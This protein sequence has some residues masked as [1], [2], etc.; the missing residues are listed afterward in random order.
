MTWHNIGGN[1]VKRVKFL[2]IFLFL[3]GMFMACSQDE[4]GYISFD[5]F[6]VFSHRGVASA[7]DHSFEGYDLAIYQG[8]SFIEIDLRMSIDGYLVASHDNEIAEN[9]LISE[10]ALAEIR[11]V[12]VEN[13]HYFLTIQDI[14]RR[15]GLDVNYVIEN[16]FTD[17]DFT[18][19]HELLNLIA[20]Y[21]VENN[22][23]LQSFH[24]NSIRFFYDEGVS[25]PL[26]LLV[27]ERTNIE[28]LTDFEDYYF[29][30]AFAFTS[31]VLNVET[32]APLHEAGVKVFAYFSRGNDTEDERRRV[33]ELGLNGFFTGYTAEAFEE[34]AEILGE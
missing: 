6:M 20:K 10:M 28:A 5:E 32:I 8:S 2:L 7:P 34:I 4:V 14:F 23:I 13:G 15:Y 11:E 30:D 24:L 29:V 33:L 27:S 16:K 25:M 21:G 17:D 1:G 9:Y 12:E 22:V 18:L 31:V 3:V 26:L 19:E